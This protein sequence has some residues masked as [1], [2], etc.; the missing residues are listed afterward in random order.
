MKFDRYPQSIY[1]TQKAPEAI[2]GG[3]VD[4]LDY[5]RGLAAFG[6]MV[7]HM[8]LFN[9]GE[10][11]SS[12]VLAKIKIFGVAIF[13]ILSGLTLYIVN[14]NR[15]FFN[16]RDLSDFYIKRFFRIIP[17]LWLVTFLTIAI[18]YSFDL[19][20]K[21]ILLNFSVIPGIIRPGSFLAN[22]AWSIG[23]EL[24]FYI[25]FP[26]LIFLTRWNRISIFVIASLS[27]IAFLYF[28]FF[29]LNPN[30]TLGRQWYA[31]VNPFNQVLFFVLG[32]C[33]GSLAASTTKYSK[34][35]FLWLFIFF[36]GILFYPVTG[37]PIVIVSGYVRIIL[38]FGTF[39]VCFLF[40]KSN[41][42]FFPHWLTAVFRF[43]GEIS[44][45]LYLLHPIVLICLLYIA[46]KVG[47]DSVWTVIVAT[48]ILS[49]VVS[50]LSY[51]FFEKFFIEMGRSFSKRLLGKS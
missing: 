16:K 37:E 27:F 17:L 15:L 29:I 6:I 50:Y 5:L 34:V 41:F 26:F 43:L 46:K 40:Y 11:D 32:I 14:I 38:S 3:R 30:E 36:V 21:K 33:I 1:M 10:V 12:S 31:Y 22:G 44:Y 51:I 24:F 28:T 8:V 49:I 47:I 42:S 2:Q 25:L 18:E 39:I 13:Y 7:Y 35:S 45:S 20:L 48:M 23:N 19:P 4:S 9:F